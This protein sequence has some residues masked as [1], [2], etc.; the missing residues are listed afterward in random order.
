MTV[1]L[2]ISIVGYKADDKSPTGYITRTF[3]HIISVPEK[4]NKELEEGKQL[5]ENLRP[6]LERG[7][8]DSPEKVT[9]KPTYEFK[10]DIMSFN[11]AKVIG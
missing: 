11:D 6:K 1:N 9:Q 5:P 2:K 8:V 3:S 4:L 10:P 7:W